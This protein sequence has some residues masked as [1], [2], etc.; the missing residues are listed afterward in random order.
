MAVI[1]RCYGIARLLSGIDESLI[2]RIS[3][4]TSFH[5]KW[6]VVAAPIWLPAFH[7]L[8]AFEIGQHIGKGPAGGTHFG[9]SVKIAGMAA[10]I[11]HAVDGRRAAHHFAAR[12]G[13]LAVV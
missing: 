12:G 6:A 8:L 3:A 2:K 4:Q 13:E 1:V 11:N 9:P 5:I 7:M 10:H